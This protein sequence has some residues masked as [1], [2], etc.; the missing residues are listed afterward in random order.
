M[1]NAASSTT[2]ANRPARSRSREEARVQSGT[3]GARR[4]RNRAD[5]RKILPVVGHVGVTQETDVHE[6]QN[7]QQHHHVIAE[8]KEAGPAPATP[9]TPQEQEQ[10]HQQ[11]AGNI[12]QGMGRINVPLRINVTQMQGQRRLVQIKPNRPARAGQL[13]P[14]ALRR[15][16]ARDIVVITLK[17]RPSPNPGGRPLRKTARC[18]TSPGG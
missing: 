16:E 7:R 2:A 1:N 9:I 6:P 12:G 15:P 3:Q 4:Q 8:A 18:A 17:P 13:R 5:D 10:P 11:Q 14:E